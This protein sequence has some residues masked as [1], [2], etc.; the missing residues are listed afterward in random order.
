MAMWVLDSC[1]WWKNEHAPRSPTWPSLLCWR[2]T[3]AG[4]PAS[5]L[6]LSAPAVSRRLV[7]LERRLSVRRL[8]NRTTRR[9]SLTPEGER[10]AEDGGRLLSEIQQL[11]RGL[12]AARERPRGLLRV[13]ATFG[14][15]RWHLA[16]ALSD[17]LLLY[18]DIEVVLDLT[19][20][21]LDLT[22]HAI[23]V[24]IRFGAPPDA[25]VLAPR[26]VT[27]R[28]L[29][30]A[31]PSHVAKHGAPEMPRDLAQHHCIVIRENTAF[32]AWQL[33]N[34]RSVKV[35]GPMASNHGEEVVEWA[36]AGLG[37]IFRSEW[38]VNPDLQQ[39]ALV[40]LLAVW[41]STPADIHAV[42]PKRHHLSA[43][44]RVFLDFLTEWFE[45][46]MGQ[47]GAAVC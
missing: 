40:R 34:G 37:V 33:T 30:C 44:V 38:D 31:A 47:A 16:P 14:F 10:Y 29:I 39:G 7:A 13:N 6:A 18:P 26:I 35:R 32:H 19:D 24:G 3:P 45:S 5:E 11:E 36:R 1:V 27:N 21:P 12:G 28:R 9:L 22:A 23:D 25:R 8:L 17:F 20:R 2:A 43:T 41:S 46:R 42:Y 15:G 4:S